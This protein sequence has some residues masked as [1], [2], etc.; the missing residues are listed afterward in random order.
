MFLKAR[1]AGSLGSAFRSVALGMSFIVGLMAGPA[2]LA[3]SRAGAQTNNPAGNGTEALTPEQAKQKVD[4]LMAA[5]EVLNERIDHS[6]FEIDALAQRLGSDPTTIFRFVRD[7]IRYEP[8]YGV[9]RGAQ[10]TLISRAGNSLD[11]SL[12]L[13]AM[14]QKAGYEVEIARGTLDQ[15][16][17][18]EL[19]ARLW[20]P[21]R[22]T[23]SAVPSLEVLAPDLGK[24]LGVEPEKL[25][26]AAAQMSKQSEA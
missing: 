3:V 12:L 6:L 2:P 10:G 13:A 15:D 19:V 14:V 23:P 7:A 26:S 18:R 22:S 21:A 25:L 11:R 24:A 9:L 16:A 17:A 4:R 20:E 8:Y 5:L 1:D